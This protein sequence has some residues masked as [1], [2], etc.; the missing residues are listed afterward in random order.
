MKLAGKLLIIILMIFAGLII[1]FG[2]FYSLNGSLEMYPTAEQSGKARIGA[3][4]I[5]LLGAAL[6]A[7]GITAWRRIDK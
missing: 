6:E 1:A 3:L 4:C 2:V 5:I 7:A